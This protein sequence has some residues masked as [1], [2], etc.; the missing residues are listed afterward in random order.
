M[1]SKRSFLVAASLCAAAIASSG[2]NAADESLSRVQAAKKVVVCSSND[3]PYAYKNP[4]SGKVEGTDIDMVRAIFEPLGVPEIELY[5]VPISGI[6]S[7]L[8]TSRCDMISDNIAITVKRSEQI[9]F[10][11]P[12]YRAG[13]ALVV[14]KGNPAKIKSEG[15][16]PGH[17]VGSYLGTIQ[18]DWLNKMAAAD[19]TIT[20]K[21]YKNIPQILAELRAGRLDAA[22]FDDMVAADAL[23][24]DPTLPVEILDYKMPIGDYAVGAGFRKDDVA[25]RQAFDEQNRQLQLSG[26]LRKV[27]EKWGLLPVERYFPFPNC[28]SGH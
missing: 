18:L 25:L 17:T 27:L 9:A 24:N 15:D 26:G 10:S 23:K 7:A 6:I 19:P 13:Q 14:P 8:N 4:A 3:V 28:C 5:E 12:M 16:F 2:A 1:P 20:V 21:A 22:A 11:A